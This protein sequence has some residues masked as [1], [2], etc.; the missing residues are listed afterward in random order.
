M[1]KAGSDMTS[2][3]AA[4]S[5]IHSDVENLQVWRMC[6]FSG[7]QIQNN[8]L[9]NYVPE[10]VITTQENCSVKKQHQHNKFIQLI[11]TDK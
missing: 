9:L 4:H 5:F 11:L 1:V 10:R 7:Q 8:N 6:N 3:Q 2:N